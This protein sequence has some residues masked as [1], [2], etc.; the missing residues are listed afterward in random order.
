MNEEEKTMSGYQTIKAYA[1]TYNYLRQVA[2]ERH[3]PMVLIL[4]LWA[5]RWRETEKQAGLY[6]DGRQEDVS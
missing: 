4:Q 6:T 1:E 5:D 2:Y 3:E